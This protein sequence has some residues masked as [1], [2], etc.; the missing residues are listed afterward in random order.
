M[1]SSVVYRP[2][3]LY[4]Y[5]EIYTVKP[6]TDS[7]V[8]FPSLTS[9]F[10]PRYTRDQG[11]YRDM[12]GRQHWSS[13]APFVTIPQSDLPS[14]AR[15]F[16]SVYYFTN[17]HSSAYI[18]PSTNPAQAF[19]P[20]YST[21][22]R[23]RNPT[24]PLLMYLQQI[25]AQVHTSP[26]DTYTP[27]FNMSN[28]RPPPT[29]PRERATEDQTWECASLMPFLRHYYRVQDTADLERDVRRARRMLEAVVSTKP[30][31]PFLI[32]QHVVKY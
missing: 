14:W 1:P 28:R 7:N 29:D 5:S 6:P 9:S 11:R 18:N 21:R 27:S 20:G 30:A 25:Q 8:T 10:M 2:S 12:A 16:L 32:Y 22:N 15:S 13:V 3:P 26:L 31:P 17:P 19:S 23:R 24:T 4:T